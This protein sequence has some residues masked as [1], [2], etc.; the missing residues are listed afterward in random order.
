MEQAVLGAEAFHEFRTARDDELAPAEALVEDGVPVTMVADDGVD[1]EEITRSIEEEMLHQSRSA[2]AYE[3]AMMH[4]LYLSELEEIHKG[5]KYK[6]AMDIAARK[7]RLVI[8]DKYKVD[9]FDPNIMWMMPG[10]YVDHRLIIARELGFDVLLPNIDRPGGQYDHTWQFTIDMKKQHH[11]FGGDQRMFGCDM[12]GR[13]LRIGQTQSDEDVW[14]CLVPND[15]FDYPVDPHKVVLSKKS[16]VMNSQLSLVMIAS[17]LYALHT[18]RIQD[19]RLTQD[20]P[21]VSSS[22]ALNRAW[23][24]S[25]RGTFKLSISEMK[26]FA[27]AYKNNFEKWYEGAPE[28]YRFPE[29]EDSIPVLAILNYG[30]NREV[31]TAQTID[32]V[33][34]FWDREIDYKPVWRMVIALAAH[35][36][37]VPVQEWRLYNPQNVKRDNPEIYDSDEPFHRKL[38]DDILTYPL[39]DANGLEKRVYRPDGTRIKRRR[40]I[41][42]RSSERLG[43]MQDLSAVQRLFCAPSGAYDHAM[44]LDPLDDPDAR[45][46]GNIDDA[47]MDLNEQYARHAPPPEDVAYTSYPHFFSK[48]IGQ[49]QAEGVMQPMLPLI[50][51]LSEELSRPGSGGKAIVPLNSQCYNTIA[52]STRFSARHHLAQKGMLTATAA[53]PWATTPKARNT[54]NRLFGKVSYSLP[55]DRLV[56]QLLLGGDNCLRVENNFLIDFD[57]LRAEFRNGGD[58]YRRFIMKYQAFCRRSSL[59]DAIKSV[60]V[61]FTRSCFPH[62]YVWCGYPFA[63]TMKLLWMHHVQP[64]IEANANLANSQAAVSTPRMPNPIYVEAISVLERLLN[65]NYTGA[66][67]VLPRRLMME[68]W[69]LRGILETGFPALWPGLVPGSGPSYGRPP[70]INMSLWPVDEETHRPLVS[71]RRTQEITYGRPHFVAYET[72]LHMKVAVAHMPKTRWAETSHIGREL[73]LLADIVMRAFTADVLD[74]VTSQ[75]RAEIDPILADRGHDDLLAARTRRTA[76]RKWL[77]VEHP[78]DWG[79]QADTRVVLTQAVSRDPIEAARG[80]GKSAR[81]QMSVKDFVDILMR[82]ATTSGMRSVRP[83]VWNRGQC[84][85]GLRTAYNDGSRRAAR[86]GMTPAQTMAVMR[87]AFTYIIEE[88]RIRFFPDALTPTQ[89]RRLPSTEPSIRSWSTLGAAVQAPVAGRS[90]PLTQGERLQYQMSQNSLQEMQADP[91]SAWDSTEVLIAEYPQYLARPSLPS[92]WSVPDDTLPSKTQPWIAE[93]YN[94]GQ[95]QFKTKRSDWMCDLAFHL[96]FLLSKM[97]PA[98]GFNDDLKEELKEPIERL[99]LKAPQGRG[100]EHASEAADIREGIKL[101]R[102]VPWT[103]RKGVKGVKDESLYL[104]HAAIVLL[105]WMNKN[106]PLRRR[107]ENGEPLGDPWSRKHQPKSLTPV[108][109]IRLG[110]AYP[111]SSGVLK[112]TKMNKT[113]V[114]F[115]EA[116]LKQRHSEVLQMLNNAPAGPLALVRSIFGSDGTSRLVQMGHFP[117]TPSAT[118]IARPVTRAPAQRAP[119]ASSSKRLLSSD[120]EEGG[121][122][123]GYWTND[124]TEAGEFYRPSRRRRLQ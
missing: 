39:L 27:K 15:S 120:E 20:Y 98:V 76:L 99:G 102:T 2:R 55:H 121:G 41:G 42:V 51:S 68:L 44:Q 122:G 7:N 53:G 40:A 84:W 34:D 43:I 11:Q 80:L 77:E 79:V 71:S 91:N 37:A 97:A 38:V 35:Y 94:W 45:D 86:A 56:N 47:D 36:A 114:M 62:I 69:P 4:T 83:P 103:V 123:D 92:N 70:F 58:I 29:L 30:Q 113:W 109:F 65:Y 8:D 118:R 26:K 74:L 21:P 119:S 60:S 19:I 9:P 85:P 112:N 110:I 107:L 25:D 3:D 117:D 96:A 78:L 18:A 93:A 63:V 87:E 1:Q 73:R 22:Q 57:H 24:C 14:L 82:I 54:A 31:G 6:K 13:M 5:A 67:K 111:L 48:N 16:T 106:S 52:H 66:A 10:V 104:V 81:G 101:I 88:Q 17:V 75:V 23:D 33:S 12:A 95:T 90:A 28:S 115:N 105:L 61:L 49:W 32:Q 72:L 116:Q 89:G 124:D 59:L 46:G 64:H 108:N 100:N 50:R